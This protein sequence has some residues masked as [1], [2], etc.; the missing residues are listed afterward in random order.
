MVG[1]FQSFD[2]SKLL[3]SVLLAIIT[4]TFLSTGAVSALTPIPTP[5]P[6]PGSYG[7]EATKTKAPPKS[8]ARITVPSNGASFSESPITVSGICPGDLL[9]QLYNNK[10]MVGSVACKNGSFSIEIGLFPGKNELSALVYDEIDQQGPKSNV[11]TVNFNDTNFEA[12]GQTITLTSSY[13]RRSASAG[14]Q[15]DWPLQ[16]SGGTGPYAFNVDWGDGTDAD[17]KSQSLAG[18][19]N[20]NHVYKQAG[21][22]SVNITVKDSNDVAAFL[23]V[24]AL[25]NGKVDGV[26]SQGDE[27][28]GALNS[29][30]PKVLWA[31]T[32]V[33]AVM[34]PFTYWLGRKSQVVS[35]RKR[36]LKERDKA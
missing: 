18:I 31:P 13:G 2:R 20:I 15:L 36:M 9:V 19:I 4:A 11:V 28:D 6:K 8:G 29:I 22:Y 17:L 26:G 25:A 12:F 7:L 33:A 5:E 16:L 24:V 32:A 3:L 27:N 10:V 1:V 34:I 35:L 30:Q 14:S 21:I 23:Q